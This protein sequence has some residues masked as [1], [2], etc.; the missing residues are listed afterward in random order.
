MK[1]LAT[2]IFILITSL[3]ATACNSS[4]NQQSTNKVV[5]PVESI[6]VSGT[7]EAIDS[8][9]DGYTAKIGT[10]DNETYAALVSIVNL[11]GPDKFVRFK[12]GDKVTVK[13]TPW[14]MDTE[15]QLKVEQILQVDNARTEL[16]ISETSF[17]GISV[18]DK[19]SLHTDYIQ[20]EQLKTG[21][22]TFEIYRIKNF[23]NNPAG[24]FL[25]DPNNESLVGDITVE[26]QMA[27]TAEAIKVGSS[28]EDL[29]NKLPE[30]KVRGS[31]IE[32][33]TY[34]V[35]KTLA[36]RLDI[37]MFTYNVDIEKIPPE[38]KITEIMIKRI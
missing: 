11:G 21:E 12:L 17:R 3:Y 1:Y 27:Q 13:G 2:F 28:F 9:K 18:G 25:P 7:V 36:Y 6:T 33:R 34:A 15:K 16:I 30:I 10:K 14:M 20:K 26:S 31:E 4:E 37:G 32:G 24:Y 8:G 35:Y 19:I 22:G 38:T 23:N 5:K 29:R